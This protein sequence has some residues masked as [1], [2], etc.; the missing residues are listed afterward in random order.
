M[1]EG[2]AFFELIRQRPPAARE[3]FFN[4]DEFFVRLAESGTWTWQ[5]CQVGDKAAVAVEDCRLG[6]TCSVLTSSSGQ[7]HL[8]QVIWTGTTDAVHAKVNASTVDNRTN[9]QHRKESHFQSGETF[10]IWLKV[11]INIVRKE[12]T[13]MGV[14]STSRGADH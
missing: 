6:F 1:A 8:L 11:F 9:Q 14:P 3:L 5:R 7:L 12:R 4:M 13:K 2:K 10:A